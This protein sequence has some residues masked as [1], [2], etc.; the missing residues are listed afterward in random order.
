MPL[1]ILRTLSVDKNNI[2]S[3]EIWVPLF[4]MMVNKIIENASY[5]SIYLKEKDG[6]PHKSSK[7]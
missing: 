7:L 6:I 5:T 4:A 2:G 3:G 1:F